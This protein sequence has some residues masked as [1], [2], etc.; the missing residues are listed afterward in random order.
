MGSPREE[1]PQ[2]TQPGQSAEDSWWE[3]PSGF[4]RLQKEDPTLQSAFS[5]AIEID[6]VQTG[7]GKSPTGESYFLQGGVIIPQARRR[8]NRA[9]SSPT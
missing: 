3:V 1:Q 8:C 2:L 6:G 7:T 4:E 5:K 9:V